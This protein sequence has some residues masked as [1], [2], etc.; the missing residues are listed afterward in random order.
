M[1]NPAVGYAVAWATLPRIPERLGRWA[2][3]RIADRAWTQRGSGVRQLEANL[4][5]VVGPAVSEDELR[6]WSRCGMRSYLRYFY[7]VF[8]LPALRPHEIRGRTQVSGVANLETVLDSGRGAV[9]ALPHMGNWDQAGAWIT[10]R[11]Y[12][13]TTVAE[14]LRPRSVYERFTRFRA[15]LGMEVL[16]LDRGDA[17]LFA[18]LARRLRAG[19]LVCLLADRDLTGSGV[20]VTF[21]GEQARFPAGPALLAHQTGAALVPVTLTSTPHQWQIT[22]HPEVPR[23]ENGGR[24]QRCMQMTQQLAGVFEEAITTHPEDWHML[25]PVFIADLVPE[26]SPRGQTSG[27]PAGPVRGRDRNRGSGS[28]S[29]TAMRGA[30]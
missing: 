7:E 26:P 2:F 14:R 30:G 11:G 19:G 18:R 27:Q 23:P 12:P 10:L 29:N 9:V 1:R 13:L 16:P 17:S 24:A 15:G 6:M 5:R 28:D 8:R 3:T 20:D 25:Q 21:F 4:R 22:I